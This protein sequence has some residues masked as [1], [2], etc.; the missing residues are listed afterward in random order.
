MAFGKRRIKE[1]DIDYKNLTFLRRYLNESY[2]I[3]P[4]HVT[5]VKSKNQRKIGKEIKY[6][7]FLALFPYTDIQ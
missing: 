1:K 3:I 5:G 6:A 2:C 4:S 7:Q